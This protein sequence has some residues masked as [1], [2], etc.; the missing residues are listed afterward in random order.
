MLAGRI[1]YNGTVLRRSADFIFIAADTRLQVVVTDGNHKHRLMPAAHHRNP[2]YQCQIPVGI[3]VFVVSFHGYP[4]CARLQHSP[5]IPG[6][7]FDFFSRQGKMHAL[8]RKGIVR[9]DRNIVNFRMSG[10]IVVYGSVDIGIL[11][12]R[13]AGICRQ[14][15]LQGVF[16]GNVLRHIVYLGGDFKQNGFYT[17]VVGLQQVF[18]IIGEQMPRVAQQ[19]RTDYGNGQYDGNNVYH[20]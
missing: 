15:V 8:R 10:N 14:D 7:T 13:T 4:E 5:L 6:S 11:C 19:K 17:Q 16:K 9:V 3:A 18:I 1:I 20:R 2:A 12:R